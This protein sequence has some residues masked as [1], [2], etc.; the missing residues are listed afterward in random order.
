MYTDGNERLI[1][2][3][4]FRALSLLNTLFSTWSITISSVIY[5]KYKSKI[6]LLYTGIGIFFLLFMGSKGLSLVGIFIFLFFYM[7]FHEI[8]IKYKA[9]IGLIVFCAV[10]IPTQI[11]YGNALE[12]I[13]NR[14]ML[15]GDIYLYSFVIG[16]YEKLINKYEVFS[17]I[18]HPYTSLIGIRGYDFP[19]GAEIV[20]TA[21]APVLGLGPQ[22][23]ITILALTFFHGCN[24]CIFIFTICICIS[25]TLIMLLNFYIF[26]MTKIHI[27]VRSV[28]FILIYTQIINIFVGINGFSFNVIL[29]ILV[30]FIYLFIL[31]IREILKTK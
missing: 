31:L 6:F 7:Q 9:F 21:N 30:I 10:F 14:I 20:S 23:H 2:N 16:D 19:L 12:I 26:S 17:Y 24:I 27:T 3:R 11:M 29:C 18:L 28:I 22:D 15:S 13:S 1:F 5:A 8:N 4:D 25:L